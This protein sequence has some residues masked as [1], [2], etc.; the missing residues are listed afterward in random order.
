M[1]V[2]DDIPLPIL[3]TISEYTMYESIYSLRRISR[4]FRRVLDDENPLW[5]SIYDGYLKGSVKLLY[6]NSIGTTAL[7]AKASRNNMVCISCG[8]N[9]WLSINEF[10]GTI[11]C[12]KCETLNT[13]VVV[14]LREACLEFF[15]DYK[16]QVDNEMLCKSRRGRSFKV[17]KHHVRSI[18]TVM[19]P[20]R[21]LEAKMNARF[22]RAYRTHIR[23]RESRSRRSNALIVEFEKVFRR[24]PYRMDACFRCYKYTRKIVDNHGSTSQVFG[25]VFSYKITTKFTPMEVGRRL[26][27]YA[28]MLSYMRKHDFLDLKYN[29]NLFVD[30]NPYYIF[31]K[32]TRGGLHFYETTREYVDARTEIRCRSSEVNAYIKTGLNKKER[33]SLAIAICAEDS[34]YYCEQDFKFFVENSVGNPVYI[35][36]DKRK[37]VFLNANNHMFY[38]DQHMAG[39]YSGD[40]AT[41]WATKM[42][43]N[44]TDGYPPMMR[45]CYINLPT[46]KRQRDP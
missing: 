4:N 14:N 29:T 32:H 11:L 17:L 35:A 39:S 24:N 27:D 9:F 12:R 6:D 45:T 23:R 38:V 5:N 7:L 25:D 26:Y 15:L 44:R 46:A 2:L 43:L 3:V 16:T 36:R 41:E 33:R 19:Y 31:R 8:T 13:F 30:S 28:C 40:D 10:Y 20:G 22:N 42:V 18:A 21:E 1:A 34:V 37:R